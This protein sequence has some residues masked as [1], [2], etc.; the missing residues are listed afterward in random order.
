V[1]ERQRQ[2]LEALAAE[3]DR[4]EAATE[5][6]REQ[7]RTLDAERRRLDEAIAAA[8]RTS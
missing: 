5:R 8:R 3:S 1:L 2:A 4:I 7:A 6:L